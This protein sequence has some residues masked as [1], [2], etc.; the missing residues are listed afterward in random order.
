MSAALTGVWQ[1]IIATPIGR[2]PVT[3][4]VADEAGTLTGT[5]ES[6]GEKVIVLDLTAHAEPAGTRLTWRQAITKPMRLHLAFDVLVTGATMVGHS[7][8]G[9]L[10]RSAVTGT[11]A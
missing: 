7:Q 6:R 2:I 9:R 3:L 4:T 1:L 11:R 10:P 8:A 5:A